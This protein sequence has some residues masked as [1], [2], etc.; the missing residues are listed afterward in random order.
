MGN[1]HTANR[2]GA[3]I[4]EHTLDFLHKNDRDALHT[5]S[6]VGSLR[7]TAGFL[8]EVDFS[9]AVLSNRLNRCLG[10]KG[11]Q[12]IIAFDA[13]LDR[14]LLLKA[15]W[16]VD[17][18]QWSEVANALKVAAPKGFCQLPITV[19]VA[20]MQRHDSK[21]AYLA[22][23]RVIA[24][25]KMVGRHV[26]FGGD[27]G[28]FELFDQAGGGVRAIKDEPG[29]EL[30]IDPPLP[31]AH[32]FHPHTINDNP[33][34]RSTIGRQG[35]SWTAGGDETTDASASSFI[36]GVILDSS[37]ANLG[38]TPWV[39]VDRHAH[40]GVLDGLLTQ[41]PHQPPHGCTAV[42]AYR[43]DNRNPPEELRVLL[44]TH[45]DGPFVAF[46]T[47]ITRADTTM[48]GVS[49]ITTEPPV[50][51]ASAAFKDRRPSTVSL[52]G[53]PLGSTIAD[54]VVN[55]QEKVAE[56]EG[57]DDDDG[58]GGEED[59]DDGADD[60]D[61]D[62]DMEGDIDGD[63]D[64]D[65]QQQ[66]EDE[67]GEGGEREAKRRGW[68]TARLHAG[69]STATLVGGVGGGRMDGGWNREARRSYRMQCT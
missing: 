29:F 33:P 68:R 31:P 10:A 18:Q 30:G 48:V 43:L 28:R 44:L 47:L 49:A 1:N 60:G 64:G 65:G 23:V 67:E 8:L 57:A 6:E 12:T 5:R 24:L 11:L 45:F 15:I 63:G 21:Q 69:W 55:Q 2:H 13:Q 42:M 35:G 54:M 53:G 4:D 56:E 66:E 36:M 16:L 37:A 62:E 51:D 38:M 59:D 58:D 19:A 22:D 14:P 32:P 52:V 34:V 26:N 41:S 3:V 61:S 40:G 46:V 9:A 27:Y 39:Y 17:T 7:V 50:G 20:D 25:W